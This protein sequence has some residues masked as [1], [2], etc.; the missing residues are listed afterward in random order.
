[1]ESRF[2]TTPHQDEIEYRLTGPPGHEAVLLLHGWGLDCRS[3]YPNWSFFSSN[4]QVLAPSLSGH[5]LSR[6]SEKEREA[7][8]RDQRFIRDVQ[9]LCWSLGI[10][11]LHLVGVGW[12]GY[13]AYRWLQLAP[14]QVLSLTSIGAPLGIDLKLRMRR[15][16][17]RLRR[18]GHLHLGETQDLMRS[19]L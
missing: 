1:M 12:G 11:R 9:D 6:L 18:G 4:F 13:L 10:Q 7:P 2:F 5:G 8:G 17:R 14:H 15:F 16:F 3:F 19:Q